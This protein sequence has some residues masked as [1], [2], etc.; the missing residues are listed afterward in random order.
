MTSA[1]ERPVDSWAWR[2][3]DEN[4]RVVF[5]GKGELSSAEDCLRELGV[6]RAL[7]YLKQVHS[8]IPRAAAPGFCGEGDALWTGRRDLALAVVTADCVP[9]L[10]AA[11]G[12]VAA[13]HAGWRGIAAGVVPATLRAWSTG[14]SGVR[15]WIGPAIGPCCY[16]VGEEV[17]RSIAD[18]ASP[19]VV[20]R[21][22]GR[23]RPHLDLQEAV[24]LQL[25][26]SGVE[27]VERIGLC[28]RCEAGDL[29]SYRR[30]GPG[31]GR[32]RA[33]IWLREHPAPASRASGD[34]P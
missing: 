14:S 8:A 34:R 5:T 12:R 6:D 26:A 19:R 29:W 27:R 25:A 3:G 22:A 7:S 17:A 21:P 15:A 18:A 32:N 1:G 20:C 11:Q 2:G 16:E 31:A 9:V 28:T 4:A 33:L 24:A 30:E 10:L 23:E 13:V